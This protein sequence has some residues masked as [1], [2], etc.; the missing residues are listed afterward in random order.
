MP[1]SEPP[2]SEVPPLSVSCVICGKTMRLISIDPATEST[3]YTYRCANGHRS[4]FAASDQRSAQ[5]GKL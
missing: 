4:E 2:R 5:L 3:A 1:A